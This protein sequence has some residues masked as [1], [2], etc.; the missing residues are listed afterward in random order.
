LR[1]YSP[2]QLIIESTDHRVIWYRIAGDIHLDPEKANP[3]DEVTVTST[4][5]EEGRYTATYVQW[6][7]AGTPA[8]RA[9]ASL[10][11]DLPD[12]SDILVQEPAQR[13]DDERP[14]LRRSSPAQTTQTESAQT[15]EPAPRRTSDRIRRDPTPS[16]SD[17]A[18]IAKA[19]EAA[20]DFIGGLP[21][22]IAHQTTTRY[23]MEGGRSSWT[24]VDV[25]T[26]TLVYRD[27]TE[28]Y[29]DVKVGNKSVN[30]PID[31]VGGLHTSGEFGSILG[32]L[33]DPDSGTDFSRPSQVDVHGRKAYVYKF[34]VP[35]ELSDWRIS[36]PSEL[37]YTS[38]GGAVWID[39]DTG[40]ALRIEMEALDIPRAF[41]FDTVETD[42]DYD[43]VRLDSGK[44]FLLPTESEALN[45]VRG[46]SYCMKNTTSFRNYSKFDAD[47]RVIFDNQ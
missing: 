29:T 11:W 30:K 27:G 47:S 16:H 32:G 7:S 33:F 18:T 3:G 13:Q 22:F 1:R 20:S 36:T 5:D 43:F 42:V 37:Y 41:P 15:P 19:R 12:G 26:A 31:A 17:D 38:Y 40:R 2:K 35:R 8:D 45:C 10:T 44:Q 34:R 6:I 14:K 21:D 28:Q 4:E 39:A 24:P 25:I 46:T 23:T 9:A